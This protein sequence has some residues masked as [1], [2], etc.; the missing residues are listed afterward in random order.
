MLVNKGEI[1]TR[2]GL[3][4]EVICCD[5]Q[6]FIV[7]QRDYHPEKKCFSTDFTKLEAYSNDETVNTLAQLNFAKRI[8]PGK[9]VD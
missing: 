4:Y 9:W 7:G 5:E 1:L 2:D 3:T 6:Y 8:N